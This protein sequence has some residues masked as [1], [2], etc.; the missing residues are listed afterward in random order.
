[1]WKWNH[2]V[3]EQGLSCP[4]SDPMVPSHALLVP[5]SEDVAEGKPDSCWSR[6]W[7]APTLITAPATRPRDGELV[8]PGTGLDALPCLPCR[9][10]ARVSLL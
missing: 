1:M 3:H 4:S 9:V 8:S 10:L 7:A 5:K 2:G 6:S